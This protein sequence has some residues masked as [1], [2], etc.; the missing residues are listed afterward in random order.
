MKEN[1]H[2]S[3]QAQRA[4]RKTLPPRGAPIRSLETPV[5]QVRRSSRPLTRFSE[6]RLS[7]SNRKNDHNEEVCNNH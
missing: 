1:R 7:Q 3:I 4:K 5:Y 2:P 6:F